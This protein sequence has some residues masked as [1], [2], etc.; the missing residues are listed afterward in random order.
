[1]QQGSCDRCLA[2]K[3]GGGSLSVGVSLLGSLFR[4][5]ASVRYL[6]LQHIAA[7]HTCVAK[8]VLATDQPALFR[9]RDR[10]F[11]GARSGVAA[12]V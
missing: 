12:I 7:R 1:M 2:I 5:D 9:S 11:I 10:A 4:T 6:S 8:F 3:G